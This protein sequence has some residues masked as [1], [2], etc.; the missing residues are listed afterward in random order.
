MWNKAPPNRFDQQMSHAVLVGKKEEDAATAELVE[1]I[2]KAGLSSNAF[3]IFHYKTQ[4]GNVLSKPDFEIA[5]GGVHIG[6]AKIGASK[7][8]TAFKTAQEYSVTI[9]MTDEMM[10]LSLGEVFAVTYPTNKSE[11]YSLHILARAGKH[12][13]IGLVLDT[14][15]EVTKA[16]VKAVR[17]EYA[18]VIARAEPAIEEA[19]RLLNYA[20]ET[21]A[22]LLSGVPTHELESVFGG[23]GFFHNVLE[24]ALPPEKRDQTLRL[25]TAFLFVNQVLFYTL[26]S[27][28]GEERAKSSYKPLDYEIAQFPE[29]IQALF[30]I[31]YEKD[32]EPIY[33]INVTQF[34]KDIKSREACADIARSILAMAPKLDARELAGQ[35][36]Q[37]LIPLELRKPLGAHYTNPGAAMLLARLALQKADA[38]VLD[39]ACGSGTLLIAAYKRLLQLNRNANVIELHKKLVEERIT[40]IDAMAFSAHLAAVGLAIQQPLSETNHVR[41]GRTD[42]TR[43]KP[44]TDVLP[45]GEALASEYRQSTLGE[46]AL[47]A[48]AR[49]PKD[50]LKGPVKLGR[51]EPKP[52]KIEPVD[53]LIMN[54]PFT[55]WENMAP[56]YRKS[57]RVRFGQ[58]YSKLIF[59]RPS[60]Q[61]FFLLLSERFVKQKGKLAAVLPLTTFTVRAFHPWIEHFLSTWTVKYLVVG[62]GRASFSEDT[63]LTECLVVAEKKPP[64]LDSKFIMIGTRDIPSN[65]SRQNIDALVSLAERLED[66]SDEKVAIRSFPQEL[67][68]PKALSLAGVAL[69]L[70]AKYDKAISVWNNAQSKSKIPF[71]TFEQLAAAGYARITG[72]IRTG[73]HLSFYGSKA[74]VVCRSEERM[75]GKTDR[76]VYVGT[77]ASMVQVRDTIGDKTYSFPVRV[78]RPALRR[79][80]FLKSIDATD[81]SDFA[82]GSSAKPLE[83]LMSR[84]YGDKAARGYLTRIKKIS[85]DYPDGRWSGRVDASSGEVCLMRRLDLASPNTTVLCVWGRKPILPACEGYAIQGTKPEVGKLLA[86]W[87][88]S[89]PFILL[90]LAHSTLTRGTWLKLEDFAVEML[91]LPSPQNLTVKQ[92]E[93]VNRTFERAGKSVWPS[94]MNQ[95][96][97][98]SKGRILIDDLML[99]LMGINSPKERA[100]L[101]HVIR[102]GVQAA[103]EALLQTMVG[104]HIADDEESEEGS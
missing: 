101:S 9:P 45:T 42:S 93:M 97:D 66:H 83:E 86:L 1:M 65:F 89:T 20:S 61:L 75:R 39:P 59:L 14:V 100:R 68:R 72:G 52:F 74:L 77:T 30:D 21:L 25:G 55:S 36:F 99:R 73:E 22:G 91:P 16:I 85:S 8:F 90:M 40:G 15:E 54:P 12:D 44:G 92:V 81:S 38:T 43:L 27:R 7:E 33:G 6:S 69:S 82:I 37:T 63:S 10:G 5:N 88:N 70:H 26:L 64:T 67:L 2:K 62:L 46:S 57:L 34:M 24:G 71:I 87:Y 104:A 41:I 17:G 102:L 19:R 95:L 79:F 4:H 103:L 94:L 29:E 32:Y 18:E 13:E 31:V 50:S 23:H 98:E 47:P 49:S 53:L 28:E 60:Q 56:E 51:R 11:K 84:I 48:R 3:P 35:V 76:L 96:K 78:M 80:S 58:R